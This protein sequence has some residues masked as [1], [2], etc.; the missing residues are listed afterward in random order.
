MLFI[1]VTRSHYIVTSCLVCV[2]H[3]K[4]IPVAAR[5]KAWVCGRSLSG[6]AGSNPTG[7]MDVCRECCVLSSRDRPTECSVSD[8]Y[9]EAWPTRAVE[10]AK[11]EIAEG[12]R[13][14]FRPNFI[15]CPS[16]A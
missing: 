15:H 3:R 16:F 9:R 1:D 4:P 2:L 11:K 10:P 6:I 7:G 8:Y 13:K 14:Y 5:S 12:G